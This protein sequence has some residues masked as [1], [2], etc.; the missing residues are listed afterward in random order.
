VGDVDGDGRI[1]L[2]VSYA[3]GGLSDAETLTYYYRNQDGF[4]PIGEPDQEL[5][6]KASLASNALVDLNNDGRVEM[7]RLE[8]H[9]SLW[10]LIE[11]LLSREVDVQLS[12]FEPGAKSG[13][14]PEPLVEKQLELPFS[15]TTFRLKGFFPSI[16]PDLN[17]DG[18][19]DFVTSGG[20]EELVFRRGGPKGPFESRPV[21]QEMST[22]GMVRFADWSGDGLTDFVVFDP[23]RYDTQVH[24]AR[25]LGRLPGT[26]EDLKPASSGQ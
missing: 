10:E 1:D 5:N 23:N 18:Y 25:N 11:I 13:F 21:S 26:P 4:W 17:G 15:T 24:L 2:L 16:R 9:F 7:V 22:E 20:G 19:R 8:V 12:A 6:S 14:N 3:K